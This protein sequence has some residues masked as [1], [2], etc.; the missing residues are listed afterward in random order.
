MKFSFKNG[1]NQV[2]SPS[3]TMLV[4]IAISKNGIIANDKNL[5]KDCFFIGSKVEFATLWS[6][7]SLKGLE[8]ACLGA[9][10]GVKSGVEQVHGSLVTTGET[11]AQGEFDGVEPVSEELGSIMP[12]WL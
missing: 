5:K 11:H 3:L 9:S 4:V 12:I 1:E 2:I 6:K 7:F 10:N 8:T